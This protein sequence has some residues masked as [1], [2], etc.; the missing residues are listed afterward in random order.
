MSLEINVGLDSKNYIPIKKYIYK[1]PGKG[2]N[3]GYL[4]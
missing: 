3:N 2:N 4:I 1:E